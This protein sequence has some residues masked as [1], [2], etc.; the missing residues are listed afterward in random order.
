[1]VF[2]SR[3]HKRIGEILFDAYEIL[4]GGDTQG[5]YHKPVFG[6]TLNKG[7]VKEKISGV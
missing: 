1:M 3:N 2:I 7:F 6:V 5:Q 4:V